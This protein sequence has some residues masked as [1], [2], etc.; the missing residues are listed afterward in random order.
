MRG[1]GWLIDR[2]KLLFVALGSSRRVHAN[3]RT[4]GRTRPILLSPCFAK[5]TQSVKI[6]LEMYGAWV[7]QLCVCRK[8]YMLNQQTLHV[9]SYSTANY[10]FIDLIKQTV[11][12]DLNLTCYSHSSIGNHSQILHVTFPCVLQILAICFILGQPRNFIWYLYFLKKGVRRQ[13]TEQS[14]T[15]LRDMTYTSHNSTSYYNLRKDS[16][17]TGTQGFYVPEPMSQSFTWLM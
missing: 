7:K 9:T 12:N 4:D 14:C 15:L 5:A 16:N 17:I 2:C 1:H 10:S 3:E 8:E 11:M 6:T 13:N